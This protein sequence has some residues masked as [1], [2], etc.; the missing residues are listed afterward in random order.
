MPTSL[1][2]EPKTISNVHK[3]P[4]PSYDADHISARRRRMIVM[5]TNL[6]IDRPRTSA[7]PYGRRV[8]ID[9]SEGERQRKSNVPERRGMEKV[10]YMCAIVLASRQGEEKKVWVECVHMLSSSHQLRETERDILV[11][12]LLSPSGV[13]AALR[14]MWSSHTSL[15]RPGS[16]ERNVL[17]ANIMDAHLQLSPCLLLSRD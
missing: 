3:N 2:N 5:K 17:N 13:C 15:R 4:I 16:H 8:Y 7:L 12:L 11:P 9:G 10:I 14:R 6:F 1:P